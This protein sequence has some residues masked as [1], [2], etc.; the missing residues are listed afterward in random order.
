MAGALCEYGAGDRGSSAVLVKE[1]NSASYADIPR[2]V[3][4]DPK[5]KE[6]SAGV[7]KIRR[8]AGGALLFELSKEAKNIEDMVEAVAS[9]VGKEVEVCAKTQRATLALSDMDEITT[10]EDL[11]SA[12]ACALGDPHDGDI[13]RSLRPAYGTEPKLV[14]GDKMSIID[15]TFASSDVAARVSEWKLLDDHTESDH[16]AILLTLL[17]EKRKKAPAPPWKWNIKSFD[18]DTFEVA[19]ADDRSIAGPAAEKAK[20]LMGLVS[21]AC[22][23]SMARSTPRKA[24]SPVYWWNDDI[25]RLREGCISARRTA[26]RA[27]VDRAHH[28]ERYK[29]ARAELLRAIKNSKRQCWKDLVQ[30]IDDCPWGR[31]Y[32]I[33]MNKLQNQAAPSPTD[34]PLVTQIV[35]TLFPSDAIGASLLSI[36]GRENPQH[37]PPVTMEKLR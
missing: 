23:A 37:V 9:R 12:L 10:K 8:N 31:P 6:F 19:I 22:D 15:L 28:Y 24:R 30:S 32:K 3:K 11:R 21:H 14:R 34:L 33:V 29:E 18:Q 13:V 35:R 1:A 20:K 7:T 27:R 26:Q 16:R 5:L 17:D 36:E 25:A 4:S 2:N